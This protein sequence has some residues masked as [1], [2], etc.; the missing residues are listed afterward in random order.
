MRD[1]SLLQYDIKN[2]DVRQIYCDAIAS[3]NVGAYR[4]TLL[5][6]WLAAYVDLISKIELVANNGSIKKFQE[7]IK[8]IQENPNETSISVSLEIEREIINKA[9]DCNLIDS[10]GERALNA[11]RNC[12]HKCAHPMIGSSY[13]FSPTEEETR[14]LVSSIVDNCLSLSSLPKNNKI[15][16]YFYKDLVENF[17]LSEDLFDFFRTRY[18]KNLPENTQRNLVK[19]I[20]KGAV[21]Q[22]TKEELQNLGVNSNNPEIVSKRCIQLVNIIYQINSSMLKEVFKSL[23]ESLIEKNQM[24]F[25]GV[26]SKF[27][28]F[29]EEL[30]VDQ[31]SICKAKYQN[32]KT[33]KDQLCWELFLN[34]FP[35]DSELKKEADKLFESIEFQSNEENFQKLIDYG[36]FDRRILIEK[37]LELLENASSWDNANVYAN[38][39]IELASDLTEKNIDSFFEILFKNNQVYESFS[40]PRILKNIALNSLNKKNASF[41]RQTAEEAKKKKFRGNLVNYIEGFSYEEP[42]DFIIEKCDCELNS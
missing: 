26:F 18:V 3:Y 30:S 27:K 37:C 41:W 35:A 42:M 29:T 36:F 12:R 34:G 15:I 14:Y 33:N 38:L 6:M 40:M 20:I 5:T 19:I 1:L 31:M 25:I 24:R 2:S 8:Y 9:K 23:S 22:T 32:I 7:K 28:F 11:L 13:I 17:P 4:S 21:N 16:G 39:L 10:E